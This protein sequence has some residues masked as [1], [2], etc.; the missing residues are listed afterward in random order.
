[1]ARGMSTGI[2]CQVA[3]WTQDSYKSYEWSIAQILPT[4]LNTSISSTS[5]L[6]LY[7]YVSLTCISSRY[8]S[9][10]ISLKSIHLK[11]GG[12]FKNNVCLRAPEWAT[13]TTRHAYAWFFLLSLEC[14]KVD[15]NWQQWI[16]NS[17]PTRLELL[18]THRYCTS[19]CLPRVSSSPHSVFWMIAMHRVAQKS[20]HRVISFI[21]MLALTHFLN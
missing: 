15:G 13:T 6:I 2:G 9:Y 16:G 10:V 18:T 17:T 1:M 7:F 8:I 21:L 14:L 4:S 12:C 3:Q 11:G 19:L 5:S 20:G